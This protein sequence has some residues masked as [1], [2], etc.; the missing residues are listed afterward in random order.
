MFPSSS[1]LNEVSSGNDRSIP[2]EVLSA[3]RVKSAVISTM[4]R[5]DAAMSRM[6]CVP[7]FENLIRLERFISRIQVLASVGRRCRAA[8]VSWLCSSA[9][10]GVKRAL[11]EWNALMERF[12]KA[13]NSLRPTPHSKT[14]ARGTQ[15]LQTPKVWRR[16]N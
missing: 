14:L 5:I 2:S 9:T 7:L 11:T 1:M 15:A 10:F 8:L 13:V 3:A 6:K 12:A 16:N 4:R